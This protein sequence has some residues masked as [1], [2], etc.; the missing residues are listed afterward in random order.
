MTEAHTCPACG[1]PLASDAP[2]GLCPACLLPV[3][4][5]TAPDSSDADDDTGTP[6]VR[7][8]LRMG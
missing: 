7:A 5:A 3:G 6:D 1:T 2:G 4:L 8:G